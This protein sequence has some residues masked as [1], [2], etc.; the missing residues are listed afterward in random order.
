[1]NYKNKTRSWT[2]LFNR[3]RLGWVLYDWANSAYVLCVITVLGSAYFIANF[4]QAAREGVGARHGG[5]LSISLGGM[6]ITAEAAWSF[7]IAASALIVALSSPLLG[8]LADGTGTK[9]RFLAVYCLIGVMATLALWFPM[10]WWAVGILILAGNVGFEGGNVYYNAFLPEIVGDRDRNMLSGMGYAAGY[11]G[12]VLVLIASL[13]FFV[14]PR[15]EVSN[16]FLLIGVWWGGF[17]MLSL[18]WLRE[19][20]PA[21]GQGKTGPLR[22]AWRELGGTLRDF[23]RYPQA[24]RFL[25]AFLL[26]NDGIATLISNTTP[27]ALQNIYVDAALTEKMGLSHLIPAIIMIQILA[28]PGS[29]ACSWLAN[30]LGEKWAIILTL[31]VF[32]TVLAYGQVVQLVREFYVMAAL[33]GLVLGGAQAVSRSLFAALIP[34]GK[35]AQ[36]FS[37]FALSARFSAFA[38]PFLYGLILIWTGNARLSLL[39]LTLFFFAGGTLLYWVDI[40]AG[41]QDALKS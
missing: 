5:A 18:A 32:A 27:F 39:S 7:I 16:A 24:L 3:E 1:M 29:L 13:I 2:A 22:T 14:P 41:K 35:H 11:L 34:K 10:P 38:G 31:V 12:G 4:E 19:A 9:K 6:A 40:D 23:A 25:G 8:A 30:R 36:F 37:F 33:I 17:A 21:R 20:P 15:G 28:I 26:Y